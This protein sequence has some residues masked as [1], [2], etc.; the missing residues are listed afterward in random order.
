[1][2]DRIA[3][4]AL[5]ARIA[6]NAAPP[7]LD[8]RSPREFASGHVPGAVNVPF[9]QVGRRVDIIPAGKDQEL[10]VYC[11]HG[12]RAMIAGRT[13]RKHGFTHLVFLDGHFSKWRSAGLGEERA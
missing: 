13:L 5:L 8:V 6:A 1:V 12:P 7:I 4:Q 11:G 9:W 3:P 2:T 10:V